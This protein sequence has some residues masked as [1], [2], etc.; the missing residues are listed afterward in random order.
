MKKKKKYIKKS[1]G[2]YLG[3]IDK[4]IKRL[5][6]K[7]ELA[8]NNQEFEKAI[9]LRDKIINLERAGKKQKVSNFLHKSIDIIGIARNNIETHLTIFEVRGSN[10]DNKKTI[11]LKDVED[12]EEEE[13]IENYIMQTYGASDNILDI[14]EKIMLRQILPHHDILEKIISEKNWT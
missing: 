7:M 14:P 3:N 2:C 9:E 8:S 6:E 1:K 13:I 12:I 4:D 11:I 10:L 5:K